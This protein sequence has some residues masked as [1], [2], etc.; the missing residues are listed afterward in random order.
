[1]ERKSHKKTTLATLISVLLMGSA[2]AAYAASIS[3]K[4]DLSTQ[5]LDGAAATINA[6]SSD[7]KT[8]GITSNNRSTLLSGDNWATKT[9]LD[10]L[11]SGNLGRSSVTALSAD[12]K[13]AGGTSVNDSNTTRAIIW[14]GSHWA[15]KTDLGTL[16][17]DN[18]GTSAVTALSADGSVAV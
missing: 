7:G 8:I 6:I 15:T 17:S 16:K 11:K 4:L 9:R 14:S 5:H 1:M 12:G 10:S 18:S 2:S 13:I 3:E